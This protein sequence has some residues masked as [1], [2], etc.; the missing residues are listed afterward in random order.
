GLRAFDQ[1]GEPIMRLVSAGA[2][3]NVPGLAE[4]R[5]GARLVAEQGRILPY[6]A[7]GQFD[8]FAGVFQKG[9]NTVGRRRGTRFVRSAEEEDPALLRSLG[10]RA[11][12][13]AL[14][15]L[16][17]SA[18]SASASCVTI[19]SAT[20]LARFSSA[21]CSAAIVAYSELTT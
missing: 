2:D 1:R 10:C 21:V 12:E 8:A 6:V 18:R 19:R 7:A 16:H 5:G 20:S 9:G 14:G 4:Q 15:C 3:I 13:I 17:P 11:G